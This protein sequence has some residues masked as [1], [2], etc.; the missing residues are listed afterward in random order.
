MAG[1][2]ILVLGVILSIAA[3][4]TAGADPLV[5]PT[6]VNAFINLGSSPYPD[7]NQITTGNAQPWYDSTQ[8]A[9]LFGG[10]P[11]VQQQQSFDAAVFQRV[12]QT[13]SLSGIPITL[14][15]NPS[16]SA[17]HELSVVSNTSSLAFPGAIGTTAIGG[18]GFSF[19]DTI[20]QSA[21]T[22]DQFEWI[23]AHNVAHELMLAIGVGENY[24][25]SGSFIDSTRANWVMMT[26]PSSTFSPAAAAAIRA[27][28]SPSDSDR[29][30][31]TAPQIV[32]PMA[33]PEPTTWAL[34][35]LAAAAVLWRRKRARP[36]RRLTGP[37]GCVFGNRGDP[38][39]AKW[40]F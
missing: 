4:R 7:Q 24:D 9:S 23:V 36:P 37:T 3:A 26:N 10:Q 20:A 38:A 25:Q 17:A 8:V 12:E 21:Q 13:F 40:P 14:T 15:D 27:A 39:P 22:V 1:W 29:I 31:Q 30:I 2:R 19:I 16:V 6:S 28:I 5:S 34:W 32:L 11:S 18:N 35:G 33:T